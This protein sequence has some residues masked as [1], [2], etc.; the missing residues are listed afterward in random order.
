MFQQT[1]VWLTRF[2]HQQRGNKSGRYAGRERGGIYMMQTRSSQSMCR[3]WPPVSVKPHLTASSGSPGVS[4]A[5]VCVPLDKPETGRETCTLNTSTTLN[6]HLL[7]NDQCATPTLITSTCSSVDLTGSGVRYVLSLAGCTSANARPTGWRLE[8]RGV[9]DAACNVLNEH[10]WMGVIH[11]QTSCANVNVSEVTPLEEGL[12]H[13]SERYCKT[14]FV[15]AFNSHHE[16]REH[17]M[18]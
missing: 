14:T 11:F 4:A 2:F 8:S 18:Q 16:T 9:S 12:Q 5:L 3:D 7:H 15:R 17:L 10:G 13:V 1:F 6:H